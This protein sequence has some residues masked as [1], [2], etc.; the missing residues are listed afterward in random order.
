[1]AMPT[2]QQIIGTITGKVAFERTQTNFT[3]I[4]DAHNGLETNLET[5]KAENVSQTIMINRDV[6]LTGIQTITT[7]NKAKAITI[8]ANI[9]GTKKSSFGL[10]V[11]TN[12]KATYS[13]PPDG[14]FSSGGIGIILANSSTDR[15]YGTIQNITATSFDIN[16]T[17]SGTGAT[18]T[19][20]LTL[21]IQYHG[22]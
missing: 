9:S 19:G 1:M 12:Q 13:Y 20:E 14:N 11:G 10:C 4:K 5:H 2:L 3:T 16:W 17:H 6:T 15:T 21:L 22:V 8:L 18:G 7:T